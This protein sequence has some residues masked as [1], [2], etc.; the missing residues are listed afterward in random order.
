MEEFRGKPLDGEW[1]E[2]DRPGAVYK[3]T[4]QIEEDQHGKLTLRGTERHLSSLPVHPAPRCFFGQLTS[5][6]TYDVTL[7]SAG[8]ER[9]PTTATPADPQRETES[10]FYTNIIV[11][12][13]HV[14]REDEPFISGALLNLTGLEEW[15]D[16]TGFS[17]QHQHRDPRELATETVNVSFQAST[18]PH[19]NL[20]SDRLLRFLSQ[21]RGPRFFGRQKQV[22][23]KERNTIELVFADTLSVKQLLNETHIWQTFI[24]FG[25]R[26]ASYIDEITLLIHSSDENFARM[27]LLVPGRRADS[28]RGR[29]QRADALFN[30]SKMGTKIGE[31][32]RAWREKYEIIDK[33]VLLFSGAAYQ[34]TVYIH[35]NLLTYLQALEVLHREL[36]EIDRFPD[37]KARKTTISALRA[38]VPGTLPSQ[39]QREI[40]DQLGY[41]GSPT[42][43]DRLEYLY[44]LYPTT[45]RPLFRRGDADMTL[46]KDA[47]NFL[48]HYSDQKAFGK[49]FLWSRDI[50]VLKEKTKLFLEICLLGAIGMS[51]TEI[52]ALMEQFEPYVGWCAESSV[53]MVNAT[54]RSAMQKASPNPPGPSEPAPS[55][56]RP[57]TPPEVPPPNV[58]SEV[59]ATNPEPGPAREPLGVPPTGPSE[60]PP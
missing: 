59:P 39:L 2:P 22:A 6:Y 53:Q 24:T 17:G 43:L 57:S 42:L 40:K 47:R 8:M 15:C 55:P 51:D 9:G 18:S 11:L 5:R 37:D 31:Y 12:G 14:A 48:T 32:L 25:L 26:R 36:F 38:A 56:A 58:P 30:Q 28:P 3:G 35:T 13:G 33:A 16:A 20:G 46:L 52:S 27:G 10:E 60:V 21:Y 4:L 34:D 49:E 54:T 44:S 50:F 19:Y 45:L 1:W 7:L 29:S 41:I 23:L